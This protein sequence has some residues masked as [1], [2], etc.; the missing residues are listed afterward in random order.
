MRLFHRHLPTPRE[1]IAGFASLHLGPTLLITIA[2]LPTTTLVEQLSAAT[3]QVPAAHPT[4]GAAVIAAA[5]GDTV[6]VAPGV[7]TGGA[8]INGKSLTIAS[9]YVV[10]GD[11]AL[12]AQTVLHSV[13]PGACGGA[14]G[15]TGNAVLEFGD[16]ANGSAIVGLTLTNGENGIAS[17]STVDVTHCRLIANGDG[18]D[19]VPGSGGTIRNSLFANN[20]DDGIDLNGRMNITIADNIIRDN[21]DDGIEYRMYTYNGVTREVNILR[22]R[23]TGNGEDGVQLIDYP[24][25]SNYIIR[26]E[27]N[28]FEAN[29]NGA[30][31]SAAIGCMPDGVT[32]ESLVGA[33]VAERIYVINNTFIGEMNGVVGGANL[34]A[35][36]N[37][38]TDTQGTALRRVGGN[39]IASYNLFWSNGTNYIESIIDPLH[40]LLASPRLDSIGQLTPPSPAIDAGAAFY[41]WRGQMVLNLPPTSYEGD[42]PDMGAFETAANTAPLV[43][44]GP[45]LTVT[46]TLDVIEVVRSDILGPQAGPYPR[47][48]VVLHGTVVDDGLPY[49]PRPGTMWGVVSGPGS[50]AFDNPLLVDA[51]ATLSVP[52]TY[53]LQLTA[54]DG[55]LSSS[56]LVEIAVQ[57]PP[58][59][60][61]VVDAGPQST[62]TLPGEAALDGTVIDDGLPIPPGTVTVNWAKGSGPGTVTL[63]DAT[64][65]QTRAAFSA[66]G[67]YV[68]RLTGDDGELSTTDSVVIVVLPVPNAPPVV[69]AGANQ[70]IMIP[71]YAILDGTV[72]DDGLP[73]PPGTVTTNWTM[74]N[75]PGRVMFQN[76]NLTDTRATFTTAGTYVL[77]LTAN[78]GALNASDQVQVTVQPPPPAVERRV[79]AG[80]DDAEEGENGKI[81]RNAFDLDLVYDSG[82]QTVG[83][84]FTDVAVPAG[85]TIIRAYVQF[86][87]DGTDSE[88]TNLILKGQAADNPATFAIANNSVSSRPLTAAS[89]IWSPPAWTV[90][91]EA[92]PSQ[93]TSELKT[94][95]QEIVDRPGW[96]SGNAIAIIIT[97]SGTGK[98]TASTQEMDPTGA[99]LLHVEYGG[100]APQMSAGSSEGAMGAE[101]SSVVGSGPGSA[102]KPV[103]TFD[104]AAATGPL[105]F[106]LHGVSPQPSRGALRVEFTLADDG[107]AVL[108]LVDIAGRRVAARALGTMGAG[109]YAVDLREH[110]PAGVYLVRLTQGLRAAVR[111]AVVLE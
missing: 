10:T 56:D 75:G 77:R 102:S 30:G 55:L 68:L 9:W 8:W 62:V 65:A 69:D 57:W 78:D 96:G 31:S 111:K 81:V 101:S 14:V 35:L 37:I 26:I 108:E 32:I 73:A 25:I 82:S 71:S 110:L 20:S 99:A 29:F 21:L 105:E 15:C 24:V 61:P 66:P 43:S 1:P 34:I 27:H 2:L 46:L 5:S 83:L 60:P 85:A 52:G 42:A 6:L 95:I 107:P 74:V 109:R 103:S 47:A 98:R 11:T 100:L 28:H 84:R 36:N 12:I 23:I 22:N 48:D 58:N 87:A 94:V 45:D 88:V 39:S 3:L 76:A 40:Q 104:P 38:F 4:V 64:L 13:A 54:N 53:V 59:M 41:Q 70:T 79:S 50:V 97:G 90:V 67:I 16:N 51:H 63:Q 17:G 33:P 44:A 72:T 89:A 19:Y 91:G 7:H 92:G 106:A 86:E 80:S 93:R 49:P 18:V